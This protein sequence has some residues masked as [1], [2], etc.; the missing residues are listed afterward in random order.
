MSIKYEKKR[1]EQYT[2]KIDFIKI[3]SIMHFSKKEHDVVISFRII[4]KKKF[5]IELE[6]IIT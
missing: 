1:A 3:L 5:Q 4:K 6:T 2:Q